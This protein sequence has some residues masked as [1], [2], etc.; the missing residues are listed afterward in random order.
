MAMKMSVPA[1]ISVITCE[2]LRPNCS[3]YTQAISVGSS[4]APAIALFRKKLPTNMDRPGELCKTFE[5]GGLGLIILSETF[6]YANWTNYNRPKREGP[7]ICIRRLRFC[8]VLF[9]SKD[10]LKFSAQLTWSESA[11]TMP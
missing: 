6:P 2:R 8:Q 3:K 5:V 11:I 9:M 7:R 4:M 10:Q 1:L